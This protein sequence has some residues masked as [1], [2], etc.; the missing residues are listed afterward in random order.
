MLENTG[1]R[2]SEA[3]LK[4]G[5]LSCFE[6][7]RNKNAVFACE[8]RAGGFSMIDPSR[9]VRVASTDQ[10]GR[11]IVLA[12][13]AID[14]MRE[15]NRSSEQ[16]DALLNALQTFKDPNRTPKPTIGCCG[17]PHYDDPKRPNFGPNQV[18]YLCQ[19]KPKMRVKKYYQ[20][21][22]KEEYE[23]LTYPKRDGYI[24]SWKV[25]VRGI[26]NNLITEE[27]ILKHY[28]VVPY[29]LGGGW[30]QFNWLSFL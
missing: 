25:R 2:A 19:L 22:L 27:F 17:Y 9:V 10:L 8:H 15:G 16:T 13:S 26:Y 5:G 6:E 30:E 28:G 12:G 18:R 7:K 14:L 23:I 1:F 21:N 3:H 4:G 20:S 24:D 11:L 29:P